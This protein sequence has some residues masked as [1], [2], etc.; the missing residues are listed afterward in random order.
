MVVNFFSRLE[1]VKGCL[2]LD[3]KGVPG[4]KSEGPLLQALAPAATGVMKFA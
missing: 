1:G 4:P 2:F 3:G